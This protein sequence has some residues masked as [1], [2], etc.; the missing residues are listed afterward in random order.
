MLAERHL[1]LTAFL[2][3]KIWEKEIISAALARDNIACSAALQTQIELHLMLSRS[4]LGLFTSSEQVSRDEFKSLCR[5]PDK[6]FNKYY[7]CR[8]AAKDSS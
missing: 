2:M 3:T 7:R 4:L 5:Y 8:L 6:K 1:T